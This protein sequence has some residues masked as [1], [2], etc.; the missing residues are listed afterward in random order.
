M[1]P[2][3]RR[4]YWNGFQPFVHLAI[5]QPGVPLSSYSGVASPPLDA[6]PFRS[7]DQDGRGSS[8]LSCCLNWQHFFLSLFSSQS[9]FCGAL[10]SKKE[11]LS[12]FLLPP[13]ACVKCVSI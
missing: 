9:Q 13:A 7:G 11:G 2:V 6:G 12:F 10:S 4:I 1:R 3:R 5:K 8:A